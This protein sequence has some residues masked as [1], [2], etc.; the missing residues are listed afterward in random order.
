MQQAVK[1]RNRQKLQKLLYRAKEMKPDQVD[2]E[3]VRA[4]R[5]LRELVDKEGE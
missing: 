4:E 5:V 1:D 2:V 3:I